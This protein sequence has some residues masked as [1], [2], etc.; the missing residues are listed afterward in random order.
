[1]KICPICRTQFGDDLNFCLNDGS[2]L[3]DSALF[4]PEDT[5]SASNNATL[6]YQT[7]QTAG[8]NKQT[9]PANFGQT[10]RK[11]KLPIILAALLGPILLLV[12]VIGGGLLYFRYRATND[13]NWELTPTPY[14]ISTPFRTPTPAPKENVKVEILEKVKN[15]EGRQ[16][17]KCKITN[18]GETIVSPF[19]LT[20]MFYKDDVK[21]TENAEF[22]KIR[23]LKPQQ[24]I[25]VWIGLYK[26]ENYTSVK[27]KDS[28]ATFPV[29][30]PEAQ[31]FPTLTYSETKMERASYQTTYVRG[32]VENQD[33]EKLS[34]K[35]HI[36]F[37][38]AKSEIIGFAE[39]S[40]SLQKGEKAK[41][42]AR[43]SDRDLFGTPKTFEII[44][45]SN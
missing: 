6:E 45:T 15:L 31:L 9:N 27:V 24:S 26:T 36:I 35:L 8:Q 20:L 16:F 12:G 40:V 21:L 18:L 13:I 23:F 42:E 2:T 28:I 3:K 29:S 14:Q 32:I 44:A 11:S 30:K 19:S 4:N 25:P 1:M 39:T 43:I 34:A 33:Y 38:D 41:F 17:L 22:A 5:L 10:P 37:Y 7:P